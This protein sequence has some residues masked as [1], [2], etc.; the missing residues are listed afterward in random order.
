[1]A[2]FYGITINEPKKK[3]L[4][5]KSIVAKIKYQ[6]EFMSK[7]ENKNI[8]FIN[9]LNKI[10]SSEIKSV[11]ESNKHFKDVMQDYYIDRIN[12]EMNNVSESE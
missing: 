3:R 9:K 6:L 11:K 2:E 5:K 4:T 8:V 7:E 1:M 12:E 10:L